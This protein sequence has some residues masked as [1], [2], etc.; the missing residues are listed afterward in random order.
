MYNV[1]TVNNPLKS[2]RV[3]LVPSPANGILDAF[4]IFPAEFGGESYSEQQQWAKLAVE[5]CNMVVPG[6]HFLPMQVRGVFA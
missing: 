3:F 4:V 2:G 1:A 6:L 5:H